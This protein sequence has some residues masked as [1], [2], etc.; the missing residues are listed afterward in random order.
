M[1]RSSIMQKTTTEGRDPDLFRAAMNDDV[2][3]LQAALRLG[4]SL[5][6]QETDLLLTPIHVACIRGS[7]S[8]LRAASEHAFNPWLRD[9]NERLAIDHAAANFFKAGQQILLAKMY[10][11]NWGKD[12]DVLPFNVELNPK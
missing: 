1:V 8:F 10:P 11:P 2:A 9:N 5:D 12:A 6:E 3:E 7:S 4:K